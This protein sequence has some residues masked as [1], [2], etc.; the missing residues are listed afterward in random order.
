MITCTTCS[1]YKTYSD[2]AEEVVKD[3]RQLF[4]KNQIRED[5]QVK[6]NPR[7]FTPWS[8]RNYKYSKEDKRR[9]LLIIQD[10]AYLNDKNIWQFYTTDL[11]LLCVHIRDASR[12]LDERILI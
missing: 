9:M 7:F 12:R 3:I 5:G 1:P 2:L 6:R 4:L 11:R 10:V 8:A